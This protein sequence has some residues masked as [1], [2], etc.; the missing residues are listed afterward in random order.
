[1]TTFLRMSLAEILPQ[2]RDL[3]PADKLR[4]IGILTE[5]IAGDVAPFE[6]DRTYTV[7]TPAFEPGAAEVLMDALRESPKA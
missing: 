7:A 6:H 5:E 4:L 2:V 3:D 1:M